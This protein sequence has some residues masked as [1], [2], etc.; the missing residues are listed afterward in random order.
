M[1]KIEHKSGDKV[2]KCL[3]IEDA[4]FHILPSGRRKRICIFMCECGSNFNA[5]YDNV[6]G[7]K[8][9]RCNTCKVHYLTELKIKYEAGVIETA[10]YGI[11][12]GMRN[13]CNN[14]NNQA[15]EDYGQRGLKVCKKW[16]N[17]FISF[18]SDMGKRPSSLHS[19]ERINN[20]KGYSKAN[21]KWAT[22]KE[23]ANNRRSNITILYNGEVK[24]LSQWCV[25]LH[26][27]YALIRKRIK[28][29]FAAKEAFETPIK[30]FKCR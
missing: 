20:N 21:C 5:L 3:F 24:N 27:P 18:L 6:K 30:Q 13:R 16:D 10:E 2:G 1:K 11:W 26:L 12:N 4:G 7:L 9:T 19:L 15:Y 17:N 28:K 22:R 8:S 23:Q 14:K 29:G 25:F